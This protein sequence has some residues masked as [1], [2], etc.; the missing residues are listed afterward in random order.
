VVADAGGGA[1]LVGLL[2]A[3]W[4]RSSQLV[5]IALQKMLRHGVVGSAAVRPLLF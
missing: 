3:Y 2:F 1:A 4:A 5:Q